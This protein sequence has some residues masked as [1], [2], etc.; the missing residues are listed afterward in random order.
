MAIM[1]VAASLGHSGVT[2]STCRSSTLSCS[3]V[4]LPYMEFAMVEGLLARRTEKARTTKQRVRKVEKIM[5]E[6]TRH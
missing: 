1:V 2:E 4:W 5:E 3:L 6:A